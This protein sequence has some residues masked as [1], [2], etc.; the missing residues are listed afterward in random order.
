MKTCYMFLYDLRCL[1]F[2]FEGC[3]GIIKCR[4]WSV[5][6]PIRLVYNFILKIKPHPYLYFLFKLFTP[7]FCIIAA[8]E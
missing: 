1:W 7:I 5:R 8:K 3:F 6:K 2:N 4:S